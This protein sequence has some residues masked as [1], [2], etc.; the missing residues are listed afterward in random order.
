MLKTG[1]NFLK[2]I[3]IGSGSS[4]IRV[5]ILALFAIIQVLPVWAQFYDSDSEIRI[6][7][8]DTVIDEPGTR[9]SALVMNFNGSKGAIIARCGN[10]PGYGVFLQQSDLSKYLEDENYLEK[11]IYSKPDVM[12]YNVEKSNYSSV[13]YSIIRYSPNPYNLFSPCSYTENY[14]FSND[15]KR[16]K[17]LSGTNFNGSRLDERYIRVTKEKFAELILANKNRSSQTWR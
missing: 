2:N 15:G 17:K 8:L 7:V 10:A 14:H 5:L 12:E 11:L 3:Q 4:S 6:Y 13:C 9:V 1:I 16:I